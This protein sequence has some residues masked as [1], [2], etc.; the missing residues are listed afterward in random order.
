MKTNIRKNFLILLLILFFGCNEASNS[1]LSLRFV[2]VCK[3][4]NVNAQAIESTFRVDTENKDI[5]N[6]DFSFNETPAMSDFYRE[7][8]EFINGLIAYRMWS[9]LDSI[10]EAKKY[11][12]ISVH[13]EI[14]NKKMDKEYRIGILNLTRKFVQISDQFYSNSDSF[15]VRS[16]SKYIDNSYLADSIFQIIADGMDSLAI[17]DKV[18]KSELMGITY[19]TEVETRKEVTIIE[20]CFYKEKSAQF[21]TLYFLNETEKIVSID[22]KEGVFK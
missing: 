17:S 13:S 14:N 22:L 16:L 10:N 5:E 12:T 19:D 20:Q 9:Y 1:D 7:T 21:L 18:K 6:L 3:S 8:P 15:S 4:L 2:D 11:S